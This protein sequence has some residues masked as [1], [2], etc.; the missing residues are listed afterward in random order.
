MAIEIKIT[1]KKS[2]A[3]YKSNKMLKLTRSFDGR[4]Q[5]HFKLNALYIW[6][7]AEMQDVSLMRQKN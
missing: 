1:A 7:A 4:N 3:I 6:W 5:L 2:N